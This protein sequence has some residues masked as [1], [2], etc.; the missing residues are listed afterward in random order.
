ML[1]IRKIIVKYILFPLLNRRNQFFTNINSLENSQWLTPEEIVKLQKQKL[2]RLIAYSIEN[3]PYYKNLLSDNG[4]ININSL[5]DLQD[6]PTLSK[7]QI[8][9]NFQNLMNPNIDVNELHKRT[10]SGSTGEPVTIYRDNNSEYIHSA[11]GWRFR[12]WTGHDIGEKYARIWGQPLQQNLNNRINFKAKIRQKVNNFVEPII[13]LSAFDSISE[14]AMENFFNKIKNNKINFLIGYATSVFLFAQYVNKHH[15]GK[16]KLKSVRTISEM[17]YKN[18]REYIEKE[19]DCKVFDTYGNRENGLIAAECNNHEGY[20]IN[21]ENL[22]IEIIDSNGNP[23]PNGES[24]EIAITDLNNYAMPQ[25]RYLTGDIGVLS[26]EQCSCSRGLPLLKKI[27]GRSVDMLKLTDG[28]YIDGS[29]IFDII[30]D[31]FGEDIDRFKIVQN[32]EG[33]ADLYLK[34]LNSQPQT[35]HNL[36]IQKLS[37]LIG[38]KL[39]INYHYV[40]ELP[41]EKSGKHKYIIS[42]I[43]KTIKTL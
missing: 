24:G 40:E 10:T 21:A 32:Y 37:K 36:S 34:F 16:L 1:D 26:Q 29:F 19:F 8:K 25:I 39:S 13:Q 9:E 41:L 43:N 35:E 23:L 18:Q 38:E 11:A 28:S 31:M 4:N 6:I 3:I 14:E 27:S 42:N 22:I 20:H 7:K 2:R 5:N 30:S 12:K 17:L 33:K 15:Q